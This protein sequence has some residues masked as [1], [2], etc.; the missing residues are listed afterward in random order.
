MKALSKESKWDSGDKIMWWSC[1][2]LWFIG[3]LMW[4]VILSR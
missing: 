2:I 4:G 1:L 3:G